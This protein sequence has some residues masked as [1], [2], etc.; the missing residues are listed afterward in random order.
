MLSFDAQYFADFAGVNPAHHLQERRHV[1]A[2]KTQPQ[3]P[4]P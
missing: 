4:M 3:R 1:S 2:V